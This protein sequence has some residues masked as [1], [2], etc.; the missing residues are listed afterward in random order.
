[1]VLFKCT[2]FAKKR[3][4]FFIVQSMNL[5]YVNELNT[6]VPTSFTSVKGLKYLVLWKTMVF[7]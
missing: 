4:I 6:C 2:S 3:E 1:M 7:L 5:F